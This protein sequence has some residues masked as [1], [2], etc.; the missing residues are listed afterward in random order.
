[1]SFTPEQKRAWRQRAEVQ[2]RQA[3]YKANWDRANRHERAEYQRQYRARRASAG[4]LNGAGPSDPSHP[5]T[6]RTTGHDSAAGQPALFE[7]TNN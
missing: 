2:A 1:M 3:S 7:A 6:T 4:T 5:P